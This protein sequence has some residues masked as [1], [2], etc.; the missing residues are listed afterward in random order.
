MSD[1]QLQRRLIAE[2][3]LRDT[4]QRYGQLCEYAHYDVCSPDEHSQLTAIEA[5][6]A[7]LYLLD[8]DAPARLSLALALEEGGL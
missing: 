6:S 5:V 7:T 2:G 4:W 1:D 3:V 8:P